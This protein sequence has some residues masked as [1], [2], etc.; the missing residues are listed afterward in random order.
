MQQ[1][2]AMHR[3]DGKVAIVT[4]SSS[5]IGLAVARSL[6]KRGCLLVL[7]GSRAVENAQTIIQELEQITTVTYV[8]ASLEHPSEAAAQII[9]AAI[10]KFSRVDILGTDQEK[11]V[12]EKY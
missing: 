10:E 8:Q 4:G 3:L 1:P 7:H 2:Y 12:N 9:R 6:A 5:G 11:L